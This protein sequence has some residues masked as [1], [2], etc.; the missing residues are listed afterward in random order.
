MTQTKKQVLFT[1]APEWLEAAAGPDGQPTLPRFAM[2]AYTGGLMRL[3]DWRYPVVVDL[4]GLSIPS[5]NRPIRLGHDAS[6][7]VGHT[8]SIVIESGRLLANGVVSR[9]T[10]AAREVVA[11]SRNGFPWQASIGAGV[12]E[13]EFVREN[14]KITVNG[15]EFTGPLSVVRRAV[16]GEISFVDLG[17]DGQTSAQVAANATEEPEPANGQQQPEPVPDVAAEMR[18][19]A[20][21][22]S[23]RINAIRRQCANQHPEIE[24]RAIREGWDSIRCEL[25]ILRTARPA[26]PV[27][28]PSV[29]KSVTSDVLEAACALTAKLV[30]VEDHYDE[31]VLDRAHKR[32][33]GSIG[34]QELLL[35]AAW[36]NGFTGRTFRDSREAM[37][38]A[39]GRRV[40][41]G[42]S[43]IDIDGPKAIFLSPTEV[44]SN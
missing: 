9:A 3:R 17:A 34:L 24:A 2:V 5:P 7:G 22:E 10:L 42:Y 40:E 20:A 14:Q 27:I 11:S 6:Q 37:R 19:R 26:A 1:S 28:V 44:A 25:E 43:T 15:Q 18:A 31:E 4:A 13:A 12:E 33:R 8:D 36:A 32:F 41:A 23:E 16:L 39:F 30:R 29:D 21:A 38:Y 35:E